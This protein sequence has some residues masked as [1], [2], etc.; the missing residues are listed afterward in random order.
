M[1]HAASRLHSDTGH[2]EFYAMHRAPLRVTLCIVDLVDVRDFK[3]YGDRRLSYI[4]R[5]MPRG[6][7]AWVLENPQ[8]VPP[9]QMSGQQGLFDPPSHVLKILGF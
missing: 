5:L 8:R 2:L 3:A 4:R 1:I 6:T 9:I 7:Y